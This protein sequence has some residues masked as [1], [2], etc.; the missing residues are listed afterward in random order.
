MFQA[1][2]HVCHYLIPTL[3]EV[4]TLIAPVYRKGKLRHKVL[5]KLAQCDEA[6]IS[7]RVVGLQIYVPNS[8]T[9]LT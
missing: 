7:A 2:S 9:M 8:N 3:P 4:S 6:G 5:S 1:Y